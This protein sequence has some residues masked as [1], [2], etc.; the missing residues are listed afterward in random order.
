MGNIVLSESIIQ[1]K[2]RVIKFHIRNIAGIV[3]YCQEKNE[4]NR[5]TRQLDLTS[6]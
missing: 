5:E 4:L 3:Y 1:T 2:I 6:Y